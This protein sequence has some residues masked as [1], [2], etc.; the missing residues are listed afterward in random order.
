MRLLAVLTL[1]D[2]DRNGADDRRE[3]VCGERSACYGSARTAVA[4]TMMV[5]GIG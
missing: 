3:Q 5:T 1:A 4:G 2:T